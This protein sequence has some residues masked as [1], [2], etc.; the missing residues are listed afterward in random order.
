MAHA[1]RPWGRDELGLVRRDSRKGFVAQVEWW[2]ET[3]TKAFSCW[4]LAG[5]L[6]FIPVDMGN[7][8]ASEQEDEGIL[9]KGSL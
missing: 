5:Y 6:G 2:S 4:G 1:E 3:G 7:L 9:F 8:K